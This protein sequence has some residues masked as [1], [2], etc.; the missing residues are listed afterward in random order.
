VIGLIEERSRAKDGERGFILDGF[1]RNI[2]PGRVFG[3]NAEGQG[4]QVG[5]AILFDIPPV[6]LVRRL[7]GR[8]TCFE[9]RSDVPHWEQCHLRS[10]GVCDQCGNQLV[11]RGDDEPAV[12]EKDWVSIFNKQSLW[13]IFIGSKTNCGRLLQSHCWWSSTFSVGY[14][15]VRED[16]IYEFPLSPNESWIRCESRGCCQPDSWWNGQDGRAGNFKLE[17]WIDLLKDAVRTTRFCLLLR[18]TMGFLPQFVFQWT[19]KWFMESLQ[20]NGF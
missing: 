4:R 3:F 12:I 7:S 10:S 16:R 5:R 18:A 15:K 1:P 20:V 19:M 14:V 6:E 13:L 8:R 2:S 17:S 11:H 9:V